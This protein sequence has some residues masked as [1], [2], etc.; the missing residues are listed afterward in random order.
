MEENSGTMVLCNRSSDLGLQK[1]EKNMRIIAITKKCLENE[2]KLILSSLEKDDKVLFFSN[3]QELLASEDLDYIDIVFGEPEL[4]TIPL[5]KKLRWVQ[6]TWAGANK[7]TSRAELFNKIVLTSASGAYGGVISEYI[8]SGILALYRNLFLY[9]TQME[10]GYWNKIES[11]DTLEGKRIL[12]LGTGNIGQ[13]TAKKLKCFGAYTVGMSRITR[14]KQIF[15]DEL[16]TTE[17]LDN[18]LQSV[19]VVI[20]A[21]PGT[22]ETRGMFDE[23]RINRMKTNALLVNVGRGF[24]VNT[25]TL[26]NALQKGILRGA[27]LDVTEPE[28]LPETHPLRYMKNV[29][30]TPHISGISWGENKFTRKRILD[31]FCENLKHDCKNELLKNVIDFNKGY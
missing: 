30:L 7:Y 8:I 12:I 4:S 16:Y 20:I 31:I 18:Q 10:M 23:E 3:E 27:V 25:D 17:N 6:M 13:E 11:E 15:F 5:M 26:T 21:L 19:D 1:M 22:P 28:P 14:D 24:V 2:K 29:V 9:R